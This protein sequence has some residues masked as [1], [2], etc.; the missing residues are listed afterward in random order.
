[1]KKLKSSLNRPNCQFRGVGQG[2]KQTYLY[3]WYTLFQDQWDICDHRN[4]QL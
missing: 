2:M 3:L 4:H 1:M